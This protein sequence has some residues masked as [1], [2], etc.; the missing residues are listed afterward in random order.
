VQGVA[1]SNMFCSL[2]T[3]QIH[4]KDERPRCLKA[5]ASLD[6]E[7]ND[8]RLRNAW[9][10]LQVVEAYKA[11]LMYPNAHVARVFNILGIKNS[12][13]KD[14]SLHKCKSRIVLGGGQI[15]TSNGDYAI[16]QDVGSVPA[17]MSAARSLM[18]IS[19]AYPQLRLKQSDCVR[20]YVQ[21]VCPPTFRL[22]IFAYLGPGGPPTSMISKIPFVPCVWPFTAIPRQA[23]FGTTS[24]GMCLSTRF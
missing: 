17:T 5:K 23:T 3:E 4:P 19:A 2:A 9:D 16:F 7:P 11:K 20:A 24:L 6:S 18:A 1:I 22:R 12:E 15:K 21:A 8:L 10:E 14:E 13:M